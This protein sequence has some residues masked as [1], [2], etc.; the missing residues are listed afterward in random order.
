MASNVSAQRSAARQTDLKATLKPYVGEYANQKVLKHPIVHR[1]LADLVGLKKVKTIEHYTLA[2]GPVDMISGDVVVS[3]CAPHECSDK[4]AV[5]V[6]VPFTKK[7]HA[8]ILQ[9]SEIMIYSTEKTYHY[10]P[11]GLRNW[12]T[13]QIAKQLEVGVQ[14][15]VRYA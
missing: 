14:I 6:I 5:V 11:D 7:T 10:L 4:S 8:A 9:N 12:I 1:L 13:I 2:A 3:G 15:K